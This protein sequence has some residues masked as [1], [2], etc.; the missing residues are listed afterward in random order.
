MQARALCLSRLSRDGRAA[1]DG[2]WWAVATATTVG[3]GDISP[4]TP[5][6]R[7]VGMLLMLLGIGLVGV[8]TGLV[9]SYFVGEDEAE[10]ASEITRLHER[11]HAIE[12]ALGISTDT[13]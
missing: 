5:G 7:V 2:I 12:D 8:F 6:G 11:L 3:Y 13:E 9:A 1:T 10:M 4:K